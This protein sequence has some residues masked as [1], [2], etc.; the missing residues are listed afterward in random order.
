MS[1]NRADVTFPR[2]A[3]SANMEESSS[4]FQPKGS[5]YLGA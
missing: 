4:D 3:R 1:D 2:Y 5:F